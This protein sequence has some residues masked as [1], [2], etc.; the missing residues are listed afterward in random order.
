MPTWMVWY[1]GVS[2][3]AFLVTWAIVDINH[4]EED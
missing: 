4:R 3:F 2:L 1:L